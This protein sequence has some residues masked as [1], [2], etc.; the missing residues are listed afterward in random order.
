MLVLPAGTKEQIAVDVKDLLEN[1]G[2]L[3]GSGLTYTIKQ[4]R[5]G[6][7]MYNNAAGANQGMVA[8]C[9]VDTTTG[10]GWPKVRYEM[11]LK[12]NALPE[13]PVLGP[14]EFLVDRG[15]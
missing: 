14:F 8:L 10:G 1:L 13:V 5:T 15:P 6:T 11:F 7:V 9:M 2:T 12:F 3:D 4:K